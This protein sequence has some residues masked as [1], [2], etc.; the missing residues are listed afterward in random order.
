M[1]SGAVQ[2]SALQRRWAASVLAVVTLA[3]GLVVWPYLGAIFWSVVLAIVFAPVQA[4]MLAR[5]KR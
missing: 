4:R 2:R 5:F 3:F 1:V